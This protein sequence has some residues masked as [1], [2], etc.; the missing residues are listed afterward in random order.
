MLLSVV[1]ELILTS[2]YDPNV[3]CTLFVVNELILTPAADLNV[4]I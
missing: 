4:N 3:N 2:T 1:N